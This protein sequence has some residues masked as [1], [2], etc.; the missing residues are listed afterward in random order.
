MQPRFSPF[1]ANVYGFKTIL[2]HIRIFVLAALAKIAVFFVYFLVFGLFSLGLVKELWNL[3]PQLD[4]FLKCSTLDACR[5][6]G[7]D[8]WNSLYPLLVVNGALTVIFFIG[9]TILSIAIYLGFIKIML[10]L[11]DKGKSS[12]KLL[13]SCFNLVPKMFA[14][15]IVYVIAVSTLPVT[16]FYFADQFDFYS[17]NAMALNGLAL[18]SILLGIYITLRFMFFPLFIVDKNESVMGCLRRSYKVTKGKEWTI[19]GL[20]ILL[21]VFVLIPGGIFFFAPFVT[22]IMVFAY[23]KLVA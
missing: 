4:L 17:R 13:F 3:R 12:V 20:L 2:D 1:E 5:T 8:L 15:G 22:A 14:S 21:P 6:S 16:F 18:L 23:R 11:H 19:L 9:I 10:V 7:F